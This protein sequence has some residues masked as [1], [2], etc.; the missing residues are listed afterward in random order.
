[1]EK[2]VGESSSFSAKVESPDEQANPQPPPSIEIDTSQK[3]ANYPPMP[4]RDLLIDR[5]FEVKPSQKPANYPPMPQRDLLID[6]PS[7]VKPEQDRASSPAASIQEENTSV[8]VTPQSSTF[9][10]KTQYTDKFSR[11]RPYIKCHV[12]KLERIVNSEWNNPDVLREVHHE[13]QF[14]T[15]KK[16]RTLLARISARLTELKDTKTF[17]WPTTTATV[18]VGSKNLSEDVFKYEEGLLKLYGYKVGVNGLPENQRRQILDD[19]F[20]HSLPSIDNVAYLSEW[21]QLGTAKRLKKLADS[22]AAFTRNARR[23]NAGAFDKA[24]RDWEADLA[25]LKR[26]YYDERFSFQWPRT[27]TASRE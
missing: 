8:R 14:R 17:V 1:M 4:Q 6:R 12:D 2:S 19:I 27:N 5:P 7:G 10:N 23:R 3:P 20:L 25:Y 18:K 24:I 15:R 22:I 9:R 26:T 16:A 13:L 21:G 11:K